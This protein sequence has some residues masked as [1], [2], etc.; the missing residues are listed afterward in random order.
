MFDWV[1]NVSLHRVLFL[2]NKMKTVEN[3]LE[4]ASFYEYRNHIL[5]VT[6]FLEASLH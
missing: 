1:L 3:K 2:K 5:T 4:L 6:T